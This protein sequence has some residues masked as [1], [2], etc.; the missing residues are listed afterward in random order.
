MVR[1]PRRMGALEATF[2]VVSFSDI[3]VLRK[4][5]GEGLGFGLKVGEG[6]WVH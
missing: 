4:Y 2:M 5:G 6:R 3:C 1:S